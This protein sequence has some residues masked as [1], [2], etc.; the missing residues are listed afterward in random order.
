MA[1]P[2]RAFVPGAGLGTRLGQLTRETPKPLVPVAGKPLVFNALDHLI[3]AGISE[4]VVNTHHCAQRY[5]E[6]FPEGHYRGVP[7]AFRHEPVLLETGG[8]IKN[9]EDL[10]SGE[11][12]IVYN[13]DILS[14]LPLEPAIAHHRDSGNEVTLVARSHG[15]PLHLALDFGAPA[16]GGYP[17]GRVA[18]IRQQLGRAPGTHLF[19]GIYLI[20]PAF[21]QRLATGAHPVVPVFLKMIET[22]ARLGAIVIDDGL[23]HDL[24]TREAYLDAHRLLLGRDP[25]L[26]TVHPDAKIAP[27]ARISGSTFVGPGATI[28]EDVVLHD[29]VLWHGVTIARGS[30][31]TRCIVT[32]R[33][34]LSG[35]HCD[36]DF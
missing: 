33:R 1:S 24:G 29:C 27:G 7:L 35:T 11:P 36:A 20:S 26:P 14:D 5:G 3:A 31:L 17:A 28:G 10:L 9:V 32:D 4:I 15:G 13:G 12:F 2:R 18:D 22:G 8:G 23:W 30:R 6:V 19:T 25:S 21:F 34:S 16:E